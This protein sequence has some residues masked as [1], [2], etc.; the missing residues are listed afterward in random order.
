VGLSVL[1]AGQHTVFTVK[2][3]IFDLAAS[4]NALRLVLTASTLLNLTSLIG[5]VTRTLRCGTAIRSEC[6]SIISVTPLVNGSVVVLVVIVDHSNGGQS[7]QVSESAQLAMLCRSQALNGPAD[8]SLGCADGTSGWSSGWTVA[9]SVVSTV[10][11]AALAGLL[12]KFCSK[13]SSSQDED[14]G[15]ELDEA[16]EVADEGAGVLNVPEAVGASPPPVPVASGQRPKGAGL[17][18]ADPL[19]EFEDDLDDLTK[20][21]GVRRGHA[22]EEHPDPNIL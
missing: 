22:R 5:D 3:G 16:Y 9:I 12:W 6:F 2:V 7:V 1:A 19:A 20:A 11:G 8:R 13:K 17:A 14:T 18:F 10:A 21:Y 15:E 4:P